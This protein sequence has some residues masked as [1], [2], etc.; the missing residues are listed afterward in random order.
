MDAAV[1]VGG[2]DVVVHVADLRVGA[3]LG[4]VV[5]RAGGG[6]VAQRP[7]LDAGHE[8]SLADQ[9]VAVGGLLAERAAA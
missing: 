7:R 2:H 3:E 4:V 9:P 8:E 1:V 6:H 5:G